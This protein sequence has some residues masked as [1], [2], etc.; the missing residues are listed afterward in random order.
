[1]A[2]GRPLVVTIANWLKEPMLL[3]KGMVVAQCFALL[4]VVIC[5]LEGPIDVV[6]LYKS[7]GSKEEKL[8]QHYAVAMRDVSKKA[9]NW[10]EQVYFNEKYTEWKVRL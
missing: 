4:A 6:Q 8:E 7:R 5:S 10:T 1:M 9:L 2:P 3:P